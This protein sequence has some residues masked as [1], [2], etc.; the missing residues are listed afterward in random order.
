MVRKFI[1]LLGFVVLAQITWVSAEE[2]VS[3][4]A[5]PQ[6]LASDNPHFVIS[7]V[8]ILEL[9]YSITTHEKPTEAKIRIHKVLR[10]RNQQVSRETNATFVPPLN[11]KMMV[12]PKKGNYSLKEEEKKREYTMPHVGDHVMIAYCCLDSVEDPL[13]NK[14][15]TQTKIVQWTPENEAI[16]MNSMAGPETT[17][18]IQLGVLT[19]MVASTIC[20]FIFGFFPM[21]KKVKRG[22]QR[23]LFI[24]S[25]ILYAIY[26]S[27]I[28]S[29]TNIRIDMILIG[30]LLIANLIGLIWV[31]IS[32]PMKA[33]T[34]TQ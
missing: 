7:H 21:S 12:D 20:G 16:I 4:I 3:P 13:E 22:A 5:S 18:K 1:G 11:G 6:D 10:G 25:F 8:E 28:S 27:G 31:V 15:F 14:I 29:H 26:E 34:T 30:P 23:M 33:E 19:L 2:L 32:A 24:V 9:P 17:G